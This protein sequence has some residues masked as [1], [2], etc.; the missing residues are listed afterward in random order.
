M[1]ANGCGPAWFPEW[2]RWLCFGWFF[3]ASCIK[4]DN[5]YKQGGD[6]VRRF[7]CDWKFWLAMRRDI[8]R[9]MVMLRPLLF[10]VAVVYYLFVRLFGWYFF[11]HKGKK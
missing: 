7:E 1:T 8:R 3:E 2:L 4:H 10:V 6:E 11:N 5:G 9:A